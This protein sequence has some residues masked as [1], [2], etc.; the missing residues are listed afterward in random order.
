MQAK[1]ISYT[2]YFLF[3][4]FPRKRTKYQ[5]VLNIKVRVSLLNVDGIQHEKQFQDNGILGFIKYK[6]QKFRQVK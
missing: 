4:F 2:E 5:Y 6:V 1:E 3:L